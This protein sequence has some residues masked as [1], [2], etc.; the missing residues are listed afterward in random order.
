MK[1][2][3]IVFAIL[4][5]IGLLWFLSSERA[6]VAKKSEAEVSAPVKTESEATQT[7]RVA[8]LADQLATASLENAILIEGE[9]KFGMFGPIA[10]VAGTYARERRKLATGLKGLAAILRADPSQRPPKE[11]WVAFQKALESL[12]ETD[13]PE[14]LDQ[15]P[16]PKDIRASLDRCHG[17]EVSMI[18][19]M[20]GER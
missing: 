15:L 2:R 6:R 13:S 5:A 19:V 1:K 18:A 4:A 17:L 7:G 16:W 12:S 10:E 11:K 14:E 20:G 8:S 9:V 3:E